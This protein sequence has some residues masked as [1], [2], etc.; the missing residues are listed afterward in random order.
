MVRILASDSDIF[1]CVPN[2]FVQWINNLLIYFYYK[3]WI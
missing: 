3:N 2:L 1:S